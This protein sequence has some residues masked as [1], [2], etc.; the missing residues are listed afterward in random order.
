LGE[1]QISA[2]V[3]DV[4]TEK[5]AAIG[6]AESPLK[7]LNDIADASERVVAEMFKNAPPQ[8]PAQTPF[9][10]QQYA[11]APLV[12]PPAV[13][14]GVQTKTY[15]DQ[16]LRDALRPAEPETQAQD[17][18]W[19]SR[20]WT[21]Y[22]NTMVPG[23]GSG[24]I[25]RDWSGMNY[26]ITFGALG[27]G[28]LL[29]GSSVENK[30]AAT[31]FKVGSGISLG[32]CL[33]YNIIR[34]ATYETPKFV[35]ELERLRGYEPRRRH[36]WY[37]APKYQLPLGTPVSWG[38]ANAEFG[39]VWGN[40]AFFGIDFSGGANHNEGWNSDEP[41]WM[42]GIGLS[43]GNAIGGQTQF[44]YGVSVGLWGGEKKSGYDDTRYY[45]ESFNFLAPFVKLRI[46]RFELTYRGLLGNYRESKSWVSGYYDGWG[47][48]RYPNW[49]YEEDEGFGLN[50]H[51][52]MI[53]FYFATQKRS[54]RVPWTSQ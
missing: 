44:V 52:I 34:S 24:A 53:G 37:F 41:S 38:G 42:G 18:T 9:P 5:S 29:I 49:E 40:G 28:L 6:V 8:A 16:D 20:Y 43:L 2:R 25:M 31:V 54:K 12:M 22:L 47:G 1:S 27:Y 51:Q 13:E 19:V 23:L 32:T 15:S 7:T 30:N 33:T 11:A 45:H 26:Q 50:V 46:S 3:L 35:P 39:V 17:F 36:D 21:M 48:N 14:Y 4:E 10:A